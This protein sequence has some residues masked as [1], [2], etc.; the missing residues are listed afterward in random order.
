MAVMLR[1]YG[2]SRTYGTILRQMPPKSVIDLLR[3]QPEE[4]L[5]AMRDSL[6]ADLSRIQVEL[7]QI[8]EA[9][10]RRGRRGGKRL[11]RPP[12]GD[13]VT[14]VT[15]QELLAFV[16]ELGHPVTPAEVIRAYSDRGVT[17]S[18]NSI[19]NSLHRLLELD[20]LLVRLD[21][22]RYA[23]RGAVNGSG[24]DAQPQSQ[25]IQPT[26]DS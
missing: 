8:E 10:S 12:L 19:R 18:A 24:A 25:E 14:S 4:T 23:V 22:G 20:H 2:A 7:R 3:D 15:R 11:G 17:V 5:V 6:Q 9:L 13:N 26:L 16:G 1:R 21:N